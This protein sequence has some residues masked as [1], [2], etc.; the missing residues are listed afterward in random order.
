MRI[1]MGLLGGFFFGLFVGC[2]V[3][4]LGEFSGIGAIAG[5]RAFYIFL[6]S[7]AQEASSAGGTR[8]ARPGRRKPINS[9]ARRS[10]RI[11]GILMPK[12]SRRP[13]WMQ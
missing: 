4:A 13:N 12:S 6:G 1:F 7:I 8:E 11:N 2:M 5:E 10:K 9:H 3:A